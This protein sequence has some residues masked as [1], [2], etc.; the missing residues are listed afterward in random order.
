M[1][2]IEYI[3]LEQ[4]EDFLIFCNKFHWRWFYLNRFS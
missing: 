3:S 4:L 2:F 1:G